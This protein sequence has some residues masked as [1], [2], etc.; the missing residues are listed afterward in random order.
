MRLIILILTCTIIGSCGKESNCMTCTVMVDDNLVEAQRKCDGLAN[1]FPEYGP[2]SS[3]SLGLLCGEEITL[4][5][6]VE[7]EV[8]TTCNGAIGTVRTRVSCR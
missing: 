1:N 2:V 5:K 3:E 7:G 4:A 8:T 6:Q